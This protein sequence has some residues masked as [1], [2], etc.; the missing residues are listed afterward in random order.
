MSDKIP[1]KKYTYSD[2]WEGRVVLAY[3]TIF[4][5][6]NEHFILCTWEDFESE[7]DIVKIKNKQKE[8]FDQG[9]K[10]LCDSWVRIFSAQ[11]E[12][13][14]IKKLY[15]E[16]EIEDTATIIFEND[17][18]KFPT[19]QLELPMKNHNVLFYVTDLLEIRRFINDIIIQGK[20][21][22][23]D[24]IHSPQSLQQ[25]K[26]LKAPLKVFAQAFWD[27]LKW[28][29][30]F[31]LAPGENG[32][33]SAALIKDDKKPTITAYA[34]MHV[35]LSL[36]NGQGVTQQNKH[37]LVK[38]YGYNSAEQLRNEFVKYQGKDTRLYL[39][40]SHKRSARV[41]MERFNSILPILE[42]LNK[43]AYDKAKN[44]LELLQKTYDKH[45]DC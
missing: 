40:T 6:E 24:F 34:I 45:F 8:I 20:E 17:D 7:N 14:E 35:Y 3:A 32:R 5:K 43:D 37:T 29:R 41:H 25:N 4:N 2:W 44:D 12:K 10:K 36:F 21:R 13:S 30:N 27:Y 38:K 18:P 9:T 1:V 42:N 26:I 33:E 23:Y 16:R 28:L 15:L 11:Y 31:D 19:F 22:N 39:N